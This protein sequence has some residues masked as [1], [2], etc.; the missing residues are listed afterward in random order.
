MSMEQ[1]DRLVRQRSE[2]FNWWNLRHSDDFSQGK[3]SLRVDVTK[4]SMIAFCG[5]AYAGAKNY[6][7]APAWFGDIVR[8]AMSKTAVETTRA[9]VE[10]ELASL[11]ERIDGLKARILAEFERCEQ[12]SP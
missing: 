6:H 3:Y 9:A 11:T 7:D 1:F 8:N 12:S 4:P 10:A 5:Q 2:L